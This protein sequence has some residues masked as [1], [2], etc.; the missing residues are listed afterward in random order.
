MH[1]VQ[2]PDAIASQHS[3][4]QHSTAQHSTAQHSTAQTCAKAHIVGVDEAA[5]IAFTIHDTKV[6]SVCA[7]SVRV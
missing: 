7:S 6:H 4:A 1:C 3:T 5:R 2:S